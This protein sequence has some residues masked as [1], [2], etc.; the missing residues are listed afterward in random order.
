MW[1]V[2]AA[3]EQYTERIRSLES[4]LTTGSKPAAL[5]PIYSELAALRAHLSSGIGL[6]GRSRKLASPGERARSAVTQR[7][8]AALKRITEIHPTLGEHLQRSLR[9]GTFG[10][11]SPFEPVIWQ[12]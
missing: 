12:L 9:T 1:R 4:E 7:I 2:D 11:Y 5:E 10:V 3:G 8:K 6:G